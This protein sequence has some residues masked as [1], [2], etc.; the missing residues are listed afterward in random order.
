MTGAFDD[1]DLRDLVDLL[2]D[3]EKREIR[4]AILRVLNRLPAQ[5][6]LRREL[7][8]RMLEV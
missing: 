7:G 2:T 8:R 4:P 1:M 3:E 5:E 6:V